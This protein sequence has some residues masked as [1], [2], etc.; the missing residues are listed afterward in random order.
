MA[1]F[2][3]R[4][5]AGPHYSEGNIQQSKEYRPGDLIESPL[6]LCKL[7]PNK[8]D[9]AAPPR[10]L[11]ESEPVVATAVLEDTPGENVTKEF[12]V[13]IDYDLG[14]FLKEKKYWIYDDGEPVNEKG[15][16]K[17]KVDSFI[18]MYIASRDGDGD[19]E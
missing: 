12:P 2:R 18:E 15:L 10:K 1:W 6:D 19:E 7:F 14:V 17:K 11:V 16:T 3:L 13:A 4:E 5:G 9:R 8:F